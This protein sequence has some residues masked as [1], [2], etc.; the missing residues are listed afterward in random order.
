LEVGGEDGGRKGPWRVV[1]ADGDDVCGDRDVV[2]CDGVVVG[3]WLVL[4]G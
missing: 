2:F 4:V 1:V 3:G